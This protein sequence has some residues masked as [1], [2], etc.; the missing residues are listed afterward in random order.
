MK[1]ETDVNNIFT[2]L[3]KMLN[4]LWMS[5]NIQNI[6]LYTI[7]LQFPHR[8][9]LVFQSLFALTFNYRYSLQERTRVYEYVRKID[10][11]FLINKTVF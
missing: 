10:Y 7:I 1:Y 4:K 3:K 9:L 11:C 5:L 2:K 8:S 6:E